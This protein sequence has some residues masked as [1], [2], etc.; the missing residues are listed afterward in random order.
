MSEVLL[1]N[2]VSNEILTTGSR[3]KCETIA[4]SREGYGVVTQD[5]YDTYSEQKLESEAFEQQREIA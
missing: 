4:G 5:E 1:V 3:K 2:T